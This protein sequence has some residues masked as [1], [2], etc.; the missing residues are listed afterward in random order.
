MGSNDRTKPLIEE[1]PLAKLLNLVQS[2][3]VRLQALEQK[4]NERLHDTRPLWE[5]VQMQLTEIKSDLRRI[6]RKFDVLHDDVIEV[7]IDQRDL[8]QRLDRLESKVS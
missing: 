1:E 3:D 2:V 7:R 4:V 6:D 8:D 5:G